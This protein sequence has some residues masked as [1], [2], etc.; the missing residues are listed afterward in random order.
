MLKKFILYYLKKMQHI[1][2]ALYSESNSINLLQ[3]IKA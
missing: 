2:I 1:G 3:I